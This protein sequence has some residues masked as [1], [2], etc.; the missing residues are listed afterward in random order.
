GYQQNRY[1]KDTS[2]PLYWQ[3]RK[4]KRVMCRKT[5]LSYCSKMVYLKLAGLKISDE[6]LSA[7]LHSHPDINFLILDR[8]HGFS[9]IPIIEIAKYC[10]KLLYLSLDVCIAITDRCVSEIAQSCSNLKYIIYL[11]LNEQPSI[12][13]E[14]ICAIARSC[15]NLQ[16]LDL[17]FNKIITDEAIC[18]IA[19]SCPDMRNY[20]LESCEQITDKLIKKIA[21]LNK[22]LQNISLISCYKIMDDA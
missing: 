7:I 22:N 8:S 18:V 11:N 17:S 10:L 5:K 20:F 12:N 16:H 4:F 6:L 14:S 1:S 2:G 3:L 15:V 21:D 19:T 13:D 9:N